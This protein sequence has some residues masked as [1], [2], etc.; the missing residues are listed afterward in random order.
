MC[1]IAV[2]MML[3]VDSAVS[4]G[5]MADAAVDVGHIDLVDLLL[6]IPSDV[7]EIGV[8]GARAAQCWP[9]MI[10][11]P[12]PLRLQNASSLS[13]LYVSPGR[14]PWFEINN[15]VRE[16]CATSRDSAIR[17]M[18][19][20]PAIGGHDGIRSSL[21]ES[22][23]GPSAPARINLSD[24]GATI[25]Q[26][27]KPTLG[28]GS[29]CRGCGTEMAGIKRRLRQRRR[30]CDRLRHHRDHRHPEGDLDRDR[31]HGGI[32]VLMR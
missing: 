20:C 14:W 31:R 23:L 32:G 28:D 26:A 10:H 17:L 5:D 24:R 2:R 13:P 22:R 16:R 27:G 7:G 12:E 1:N 6:Q 9:P 30:R 8:S 4:G 18:I 29:Q 11:R 25:G 19:R 3:V 21:H 15:A